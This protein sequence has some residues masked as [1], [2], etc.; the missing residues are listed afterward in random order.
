MTE[1]RKFVSSSSGSFTESNDILHSS[2]FM[3]YDLNIFLLKDVIYNIIFIR[4]VYQN[5]EKIVTGLKRKLS[6]FSKSFTLDKISSKVNN[7]YF[8][9]KDDRPKSLTA[10]ENMDILDTE[11]N[12]IYYPVFH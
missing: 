3:R 9:K 7:R 12:V 4:N 2:T 1:K 6:K 8:S 5:S 11:F 10:I